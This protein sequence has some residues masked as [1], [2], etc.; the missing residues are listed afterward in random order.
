[1]LVFFVVRRDALEGNMILEAASAHA[2]ERVR[3][4]HLLLA[5]ATAEREKI[6]ASGI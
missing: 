3:V 2:S 1:M 5:A 4:F 6:V